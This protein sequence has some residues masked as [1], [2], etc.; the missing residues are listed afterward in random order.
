MHT[1]LSDRDE[2]DWPA[3]PQNRPLRSCDNRIHGVVGNKVVVTDTHPKHVTTTKSAALGAGFKI[4]HWQRPNREYIVLNFDTISQEQLPNGTPPAPPKPDGAGQKR[5]KK[6]RRDMV[7]WSKALP[8]DVF[9]QIYDA[10]QDAQRARMHNN[11]VPEFEKM[12]GTFF[13][14]EKT[15]DE[16][17]Y[18]CS[19]N[20]TQILKRFHIDEFVFR[21]FIDACPRAD[22][23]EWSDLVNKYKLSTEYESQLKI[24]ITDYRKAEALL[25]PLQMSMEQALAYVRK[26]DVFPHMTKGDLVTTILSEH[27]PSFRNAVCSVKRGE[28]IMKNIAAGFDTNPKSGDVDVTPELIER[29]IRRTEPTSDRQR[30]LRRMFYSGQLTGPIVTALWRFITVQ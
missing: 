6:W 30:D 20:Q 14:Y 19:Q 1:F 22:T 18:L 17:R 7:Q 25:E 9:W 10:Q 23:E 4:P 21:A 24:Y 26:S 13:G 3:L 29:F 15:A 28:G 5:T 12:Y 27:W 8:D 16:L 11:S 2:A